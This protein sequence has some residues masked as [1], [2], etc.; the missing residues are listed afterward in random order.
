MN[1]GMGLTLILII[2]EV[3]NGLI[4]L[5]TAIVSHSERWSREVRCLW[6]FAEASIMIR[7]RLLLHEAIFFHFL[8]KKSES[9]Y[10][11]QPKS[12]VK[13]NK[14]TNP[15]ESPTKSLLLGTLN[16]IKNQVS[17][18]YIQLHGGS[19]SWGG[20]ASLHPLNYSKYKQRLISR[21]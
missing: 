12:R 21:L 14:A 18:Q 10:S 1:Y 20:N 15:M 19:S 7:A 9:L 3:L 4:W 8:L 6:L 17:W 11:Y 13:Y 5:F 16:V 2:N